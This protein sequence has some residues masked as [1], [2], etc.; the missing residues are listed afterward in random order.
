MPAQ[1][2]SKMATWQL[3]YLSCRRTLGRMW[4]SSCTTQG[5]G[6]GK[7]DSSN[8]RSWTWPE[9]RSGWSSHVPKAENLASSHFDSHRRSRHCCK[10]DGSSETVI[11]C[12]TSRVSP[13]GKELCVAP[14]LVLSNALALRES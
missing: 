2:S 9:S 4:S 10:N 11:T 12:S 7:D 5:G 6:V 8:G 1:G 13:S 3:C 14:G